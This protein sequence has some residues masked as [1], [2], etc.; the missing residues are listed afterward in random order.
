[1]DSLT[2]SSATEPDDHNDRGPHGLSDGRRLVR[3]IGLITVVVALVT[4]CI[5]FLVL[6]GLSPIEP[7]RPVIRAAMVINT[8]LVIILL[9]TIAL[10]LHSLLLARRRGRAAARL[11][12]R[13]VTLFSL[14]AAVPA[15]IVAAIAMITLDVGLDRWF[16]D[17]T[18]Q[19]VSNALTVANAYVQEHARV[20][21]GDLIAMAKDMDRFKVIYDTEP[22]RFDQL[23]ATQLTLRQIPAAFLLSPDGSI[24]TSLILDPKLNILMPPK[25]VL[26]RAEEGEPVLIAPGPSNLVGGVMK[27]DS[28]DDTYLYVTR[29]LDSRVVEYLRITQENAAEYAKLEES[30]FG[31]Q[32]AFGLIYVGVTLVLLL[33]AIWIGL[34]FANRLVAPIRRLIGATDQVARGN[35]DVDVPIA[36][37]EGDL[38]R[39]GTTFNNMMTELRNQRSELL[40]ASDQI[41]RRRRFTEAVLSGVSAGVL[42]VDQDGSISLANSS[43]QQLLAVQ[44]EQLVGKTIADTVPE[45]AG[46]VDAANATPPTASHAQITLTRDGRERTFLVQVTSEQSTGRE[47]GLVVTFDDITDLVTAQRSSA[48]A[49][50]ARRIAHEIKNPLTPIQLSAERIKRRYGKRIEDDRTVF[51]QCI[52][53][54]VRQVGDI[55]RMVDEFSSFARMPKAVMEERDLTETVSEAVFLIGVGH[56]EIDFSTDFES[57]PMIGEFDHRLIGQAVGNVAKNAAEAIEVALADHGAKGRIR[58]EVRRTGGHSV[59]DLI[60]NGVRWPKENRQRLLEPYMT[61]RAKGTDLGLAIVG[62]IMEEHDGRVELL[63]APNIADGESGAIVRLTMAATGGPAPEQQDNE[64]VAEGAQ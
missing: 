63:D 25:G 26:K 29:A 61:T 49:D 4:V 12:I 52:D 19:I 45:L 5:S 9:S 31:V 62:K 32:I 16:Q 50:V 42:G 11:H 36:R 22:S 34:G 27:L 58:V 21:R 57:H 15:I 24:V 64:K 8:L 51:D 39:L 47:H 33:S 55:G 28:Y 3:R 56:P 54:I 40:A 2:K 30:R 44:G 43:A 10:E 53:T 18:Q 7:T 41:D 60:D 23:F 14:I 35:L 13:I 46:I 59:I 1:M 17:R 20:L 37:R 48:W 38:A 6:T